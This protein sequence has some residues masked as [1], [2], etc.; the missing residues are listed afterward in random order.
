MSKWRFLW[1]TDLHYELPD[2]NYLDDPKELK[3]KYDA[4]FRENVF[5]NFNRILRYGGF[6]NM[7]LDFIVIGGDITTHGNRRGFDTFLAQA[8]PLLQ[9]LVPTKAICIVPGNHDVVWGI[10]PTEEGYFR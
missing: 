7:E 4:P 8:F 6:E 10:D 5:T 9:S 3:E 2:A 1:I